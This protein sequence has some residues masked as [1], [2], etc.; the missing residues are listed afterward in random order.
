MRVFNLCSI[1]FLMFSGIGN[2]DGCQTDIY[3][4]LEKLQ[5][6]L[7]LVPYLTSLD[8]THQLYKDERF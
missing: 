7:K 3:K 8:I 4:L 5:S 2:K 6:L 1:L